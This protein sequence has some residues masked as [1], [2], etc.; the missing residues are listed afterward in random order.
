MAHLPKPI[1][2]PTSSTIK[3]ELEPDQKK[4]KVRTFQNQKYIRFIIDIVRGIKKSKKCDHGRDFRF[5]E[6]GKIFETGQND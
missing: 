4:K 2:A 5:G 1:P 3:T 6:R